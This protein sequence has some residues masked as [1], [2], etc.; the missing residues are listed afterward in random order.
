MTVTVDL[1]GVEDGD[2]VELTLESDGSRALLFDDWKIA[3][4]GLA[5][6]VTVPVPESTS[7][8]HANGVSI[9]LESSDFVDLWALPG[10][11]AFDPYGGSEWLEPV[12][13]RTVVP[14]ST[15]GLYAVIGEAEPSEELK[16]LVDAEIATWV[17]GCM[18]ST[19]ADPA[20]CPQE[21][22]P[23]GDDYRNLTW[24]LVTMPTVSWEG[25]YGTF[26]ADLWSEADGEATATYEYDES[27]G[28]GKPDW[29]DETEETTFS[30]D[31]EVDLVDGEPQVTF[32]SY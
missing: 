12:D 32:E 17:E 27:H 8:L 25:F 30:V 10:S 4:G 14:A 13:G 23:F 31:L 6:V 9:P 18:A 11:Y 7:S 21:V 20:D 24:S 16:D 15:W 19:D 26:P 28:I 29:T 22:Y 2:A 3:E 1:E 5:S